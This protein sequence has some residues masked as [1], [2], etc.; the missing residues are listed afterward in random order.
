MDPALKISDDELAL[1]KKY[2]RSIEDYV[3]PEEDM[4]AYYQQFSER[5]ARVEG[6]EAVR[7]FHE[8]NKKI[9]KEF[10]FKHAEQFYDISKEGNESIN[11]FAVLIDS[12]GESKKDLHNVKEI[13]MLKS[14]AEML[15]K[16]ESKK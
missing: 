2:L 6:R 11:D 1:L 12:F 7:R 3:S 4:K 14:F 16:K 15:Q 5:A 13:N 8:L 9:D 10:H